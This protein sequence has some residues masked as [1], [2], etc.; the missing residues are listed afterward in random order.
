MA[1]ENRGVTTKPEILLLDAD[2]LAG[3][4]LTRLREQYHVTLER[5][6]TAAAEYLRRASS[7]C[8]FL[9]SDVRASG[10]ETLPLFRT[11]KSLAVPPTIL[12]TTAD[13]ERVPD[14]LICG[15]DAVLLKPF[16]PNLLFSRL[17]RLKQERDARKQREAVSSLRNPHPHD[18][19]HTVDSLDVHCPHCNAAGAVTF[20]FLSYRRAWYACLACKK[21]WIAKLTAT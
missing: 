7:N 18:A 11:A 4:H 13:V 3:I 20:D 21:A 16:S 10:D 1:D 17:G 12:V 14:A 19:P 9:I 6:V 2:A 8:H 5:S 15:G